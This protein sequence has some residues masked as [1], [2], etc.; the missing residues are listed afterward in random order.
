MVSARMQAELPR[1]S[2]TFEGFASGRGIGSHPAT[3]TGF[4]RGVQGYQGILAVIWRRGLER[5]LRV[6][7]T[8]QR[9]EMHWK[10]E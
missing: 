6:E 9:S 8:L 10:E 7:T 3:A 2:K 1:R 5:A 4:G